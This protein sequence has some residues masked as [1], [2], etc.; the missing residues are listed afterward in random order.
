MRIY[1]AISIKNIEND[2]E[3]AIFFQHSMIEKI[4]KETAP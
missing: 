3:P 1:L 4:T 2:C